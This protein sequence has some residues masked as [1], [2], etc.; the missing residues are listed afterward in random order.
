MIVLTLAWWIMATEQN[1]GQCPPD[2]DLQAAMEDV[3]WVLDRM[4]ALDTEGISV[5]GMKRSSD[6]AGTQ[7]NVAVKKR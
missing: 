5:A 4:I 1:S 3:E 7:D 6:E 2:A